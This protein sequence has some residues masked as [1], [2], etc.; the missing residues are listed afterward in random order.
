MSKRGSFHFSVGRIASIACL[1]EVCAAKPG[2][3]HRG[4]DFDDLTLTDFAISAEIVG[5]SID[6]RKSDSVGQLVHDIVSS[7][8]EIVQTNTNLG[9]SLLLGPLAIVANKED[10]D[11]SNIRK[12]LKALESEDAR[13]VYDAIRLAGPSGLGVSTE[14]DIQ[15]EPPNDILDAMQFSS[16][17]DLVA[18]QYSNNFEQV[19]E[20]VVP[21]L[22]AGEAQFG[23]LTEAIIYS[24]VSMLARYGDSLIQRKCGADV[25][26]QAKERAGHALL[27]LVEKPDRQHYYDAVGD[28]DFWLRSDGHQRNPGTT[29][30][31]IVAGLFVAMINE[32]IS[33]PFA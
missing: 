20:E 18:R 26:N 12:Q 30:D 2:N 1:L 11:Q 25:S 7:T 32:Q 14:M 8:A 23:C 6:S 16:D 3:V 29:A 27:Q 17:K 24:H 22:V 4:A 13:L 28:L 5:Q 19:F 31:L 9:I 33:P 15:E 21:M 10:L